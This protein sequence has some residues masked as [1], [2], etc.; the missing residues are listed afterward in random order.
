M[1]LTAESDH[2]GV[3]AS[4]NSLI[5]QTQEQAHKSHKEMIKYI[6]A[7]CPEMTGTVPDLKPQSRIPPGNSFRAHLSQIFRLALVLEE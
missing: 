3:Q 1:Y 7:N 4:G 2:V 5:D 6:G